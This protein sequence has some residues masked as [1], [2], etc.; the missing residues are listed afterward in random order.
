MMTSQDS[1]T[2]GPGTD[3]ATTHCCGRMSPT[4][5]PWAWAAATM[6]PVSLSQALRSLAPVL[7]AA[8]VRL[9]L[10]VLALMSL[11]FVLLGWKCERN[12]AKWLNRDRECVLV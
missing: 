8:R 6:A 4:M 3:T 5:V 2:A 11:V 12:V 1:A 7:L 9:L 10:L